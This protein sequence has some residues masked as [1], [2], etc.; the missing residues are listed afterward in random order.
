MYV[1][2][3]FSFN[4]LKRCQFIVKGLSFPWKSKGNDS[5]FG[6]QCD[7]LKVNFQQNSL[8]YSPEVHYCVKDSFK[9]MCPC[10]WQ[11]NGSLRDTTQ[12]FWD[13]TNTV[14]LCAALQVN[15][16]GILRC[17]WR[18]QAHQ[19]LTNE[20]IRCPAGYEQ[21]GER[22]ELVDNPAWGGGD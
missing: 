16:K 9:L 13:A 17:C 3:I 6:S 20:R 1:S 11:N 2:I 22:T 5:K 19:C 14:W 8:K 18:S 12:S 10:H 15:T 21:T 4:P 7:T